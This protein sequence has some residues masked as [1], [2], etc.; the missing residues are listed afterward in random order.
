[1]K[2]A[3]E[4]INHVATS[5]RDAVR[6]VL[7]HVSN[8]LREHVTF[9]AES[10]NLQSELVFV[11]VRNKR[12]SRGSSV[13]ENAITICE[14]EDKI[15]FKRIQESLRNKGVSTN[16]AVQQIIP[17]V[18]ES[19][20]QCNKNHSGKHGDDDRIKINK[21]K[22]QQ[23]KPEKQDI[24]QQNK[25]HKVL[26]KTEKDGT[27]TWVERSKNNANS[28]PIRRRSVFDAKNNRMIKHVKS[29]GARSA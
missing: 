3:R 11:P 7:Q 26:I 13:H 15:K 2:N 28:D 10:V 16:F 17:Y 1:M 14:D 4:E 24:S 9:I 23:L 20:Y 5:T 22:Q 25:Y 8:A 27:C 19:Q 6:P 18:I 21:C 12:T 29:F